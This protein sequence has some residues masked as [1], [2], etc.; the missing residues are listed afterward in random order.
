MLYNEHHVKKGEHIMT[1]KEII[2][3]FD[4]ECC[5]KI[6]ETARQI[7]KELMENKPFLF[8]LDGYKKHNVKPALAPFDATQ[9]ITKE[10][11]KSILTKLGVKYN[12]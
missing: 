5:A 8:I 9:D 11:T 6:A 10:S 3:L 2:T 7:Q 4:D 12:A 1:E